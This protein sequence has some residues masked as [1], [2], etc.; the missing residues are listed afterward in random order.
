MHHIHG[1]VWRHWPNVL[2]AGL[3]TLA[4]AVPPLAV[5]LPRDPLVIAAGRPEPG[6][7]VW[8]PLAYALSGL[9]AAPAGPAPNPLAQSELQQAR[10]CCLG[11]LVWVD[12][13]LPV[14]LALWLGPLVLAC[15]LLKA[16]DLRPSGVE[17]SLPD[18]P[19][20]PRTVPACAA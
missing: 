4:S 7:T 8:F 11:A 1:G 6:P 10:R 12:P 13:A 3:F 16:P 14:R 19:P 15:L 9:P 2:L 18:P 5:L 17:P 20:R